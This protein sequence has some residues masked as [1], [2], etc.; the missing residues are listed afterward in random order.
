MSDRKKEPMVTMAEKKP[1]RNRPTSLNLSAELWDALT[2]ESE[3]TDI[4][5]S[6]LAERMIWAG[7]RKLARDRN[8]KT[9]AQEG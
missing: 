7:L 5:R 2:A 8:Q 6:A 3:H 1:T 9:K 4:S